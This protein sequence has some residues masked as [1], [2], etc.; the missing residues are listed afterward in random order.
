MTK[1]E[2]TSRWDAIGLDRLS[3]ENTREKL[4]GLFE[5]TKT[6]IGMVHFLIYKLLK[7]LK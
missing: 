5:E 7:K 1:H 4:T 2:F 6:V 3:R